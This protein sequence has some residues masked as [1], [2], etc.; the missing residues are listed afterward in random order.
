MNYY[1]LL[2]R[3]ASECIVTFGVTLSRCVCTPSRGEGTALHLERFFYRCLCKACFGAVR[4]QDYWIR[5]IITRKAS[6]RWQTR[7]TLAKSLHGL[8]KS[9]GV[10]SCIASLPIDSVPMVSYYRPHSRNGRGSLFLDPTRPDPRF[11]ADEW[12]VTRPDP[13][14]SFYA[15]PKSK[16]C[17][18]IFHWLIT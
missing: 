6:C 11:G 15:V 18:A 9:S 2:R 4:W 14:Q 10:I 3:L 12:P 16:N 13:A 8:R 7:A 17:N 5:P 1:Y